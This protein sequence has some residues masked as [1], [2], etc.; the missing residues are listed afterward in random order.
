[1]AME[2]KAGM[3]GGKRR[4]ETARP[5]GKAGDKSEAAGTGTEKE[6][7]QCKGY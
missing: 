3:A 4:K 7:G 1:M 5:P 2:A 6:G